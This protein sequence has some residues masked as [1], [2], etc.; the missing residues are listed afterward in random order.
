MIATGF[1]RLG[2]WNDEPNDPNEYK[3]DRLEDMVGATTHGVPRPDGQVRPLPRPQVRPDPADRLLPHGRGVL[4]RVRSSPGRANCLGGPDAEGA[5]R[6][7]VLGWTDRGRDVPPLKLL[8]KGDPNRPGA[9]VEPGHLSMIPALDKPLPAPP[10]GR[11][12]D[13]R[14]GCSWRS[15]S[16]TRRTR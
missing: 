13:A 14:G 8:K 4:G 3:Y 2:T 9:V 7:G 12:D 16:P 15:G 5:R 1:L 10:A 11:E 6:E